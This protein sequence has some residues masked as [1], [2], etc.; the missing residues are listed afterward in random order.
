[1]PLYIKKHQLTTIKKATEALSDSLLNWMELA[2]DEDKRDYDY[3]A[4]Q[5]GDHALKVLDDIR[6]RKD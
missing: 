3:E 1:M 4:I 6:N 5:K 2:D